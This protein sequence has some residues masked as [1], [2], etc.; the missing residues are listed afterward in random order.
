MM[1]PSEHNGASSDGKLPWWAFPL[2]AVALVLAPPDRADSRVPK[3]ED[4]DP[5]VIGHPEDRRGRAASKPSD[6]PGR[7]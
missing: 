4:A 7:T 3:H 6:I 2:A 1:R 5:A